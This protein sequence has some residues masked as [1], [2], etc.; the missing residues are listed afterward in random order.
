VE[1]EGEKRKKTIRIFLG[2][3][4]MFLCANF[5]HKGPN[6]IE[7]CLFCNI[8]NHQKKIDPY[9]LDCCWGEGQT[10]MTIEKIIE[11]TKIEPVFKIDIDNIVPLPLHIKLGLTKDYL[12][13]L[14]ETVSSTFFFEKS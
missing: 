5:H 13:L 6:S 3:D 9:E 1:N 11:K 12:M 8:Q 7:F 2:G 10:K 4:Y 14:L